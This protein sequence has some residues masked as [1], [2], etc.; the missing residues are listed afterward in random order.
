[1]SWFALAGPSPARSTI[2]SAPVG[3]WLHLAL[4][5][6]PVVGLGGAVAGSPSVAVAGPLLVVLGCGEWRRR[7]RLRRAVARAEAL[8]VA[9]DGLLQ[10]L[11]SGASLLQACRWSAPGG[12][13]L[14]ASD[15]GRPGNPP[16]HEDGPLGPMGRSLG[17]GATLAAAAERLRHDADPSVRLVG[18]TIMVLAI[19]GGPA[20]PALRRLRHT[21]VGRVHRRRR[22]EAN[23]AGALASAGLLALAPGCFALVL[24]GIEPALAHFYLVEPEGAAC[25]TGAVVLSA[26]GWWWMQRV[27]AR[28]GQERS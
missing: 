16:G 11:R 2:S 21:L 13:G 23:A 5:L 15:H 20:V 18:V 25:I 19:S 22:A 24:A 14:S 4:V 17:Q 28:C 26:A 6:A 3:R 1:M 7:H 8:P 9:I 12:D 27:V 10:Q